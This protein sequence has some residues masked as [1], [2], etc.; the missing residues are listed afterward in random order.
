M[1]FLRKSHLIR[2]VSVETQESSVF[3]RGNCSIQVPVC[4]QAGWYVSE[5]FIIL[6]LGC[7]WYLID[8]LNSNVYL[9]IISYTGLYLT[10]YGY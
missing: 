5:V 9:I 6:A 8:G 4:E 7:Y 1:V 2:G 3:E 10:L